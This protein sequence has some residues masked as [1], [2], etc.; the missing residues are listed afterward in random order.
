MSFHEPIGEMRRTHPSKVGVGLVHGGIGEVVVRAVDDT[1]V[2][3]TESRCP[4]LTL[5]IE[6]LIGPEK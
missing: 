3:S 1:E 6:I 4:W 2:E 5:P